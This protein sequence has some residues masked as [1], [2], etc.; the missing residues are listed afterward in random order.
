M[1]RDISNEA[2][3]NVCIKALTPFHSDMQ[4]I[5]ICPYRLY[6]LRTI[7]AIRGL[8]ESRSSD[9]NLK[10]RHLPRIYEHFY[11]DGADG[12]HLLMVTEDM[13]ATL[14][15][16]KESLRENNK[17]PHYQFS[18]PFVRCVVTQVLSALEV[19]HNDCAT[20]HTGM[21][22]CTLLLKRFTEFVA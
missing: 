22:S 14:D 19:L 1:D 8:Q 7:Q 12:Q 16:L 11:E 4:S 5:T 15:E 20:V 18:M 10:L 17:N 13:V 9:R 3:N 21:H 6:E 2:D